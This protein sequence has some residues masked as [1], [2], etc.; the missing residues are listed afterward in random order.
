MMAPANCKPSRRVASRCSLVPRLSTFTIAFQA[1]D[2]GLR[3]GTAQHREVPLPRPDHDGGP[4][5]PALQ[6]QACIAGVVFELLLARLCVVEGVAGD[7]FIVVHRHLA[8]LTGIAVGDPT[9][10]SRSGWCR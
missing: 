5:V 6:G 4:V 2:G 7:D 8:K 10:G 9:S 1:A 3:S